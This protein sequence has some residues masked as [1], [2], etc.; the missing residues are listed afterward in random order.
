MGPRFMKLVQPIDFNVT[1]HFKLKPENHKH[2]S[3]GFSHNSSGM[4]PYKERIVLTGLGQFTTGAGQHHS[5]KG[6]FD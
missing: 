2:L 4:E 1:L 5:V 6:E 3:Q